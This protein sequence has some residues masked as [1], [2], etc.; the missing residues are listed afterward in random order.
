MYKTRSGDT[1]AGL[2][3]LIAENVIPTIELGAIKFDVKEITFKP[4]EQH[5]S[6]GVG[7]TLDWK[8]VT[9]KFELTVESKEGKTVLKNGKAA[10]MVPLARNLSLGVSGSIA[11][12]KKKG[13]LGLAIFKEYGNKQRLKLG[14]TYSDQIEERF[15]GQ[16]DQRLMLGV[17][18][19]FHGP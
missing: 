14:L 3:S 11:P 17:G 5:V 9:G 13:E 16:R 2:A 1:V 19:T 10:L 18:I 12:P 4:S 15:G 7:A 8:G 6:L